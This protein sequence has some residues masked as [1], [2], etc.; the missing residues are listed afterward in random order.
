MKTKLLGII[1]IVIIVIVIIGC[2]HDEPPPPQVN[3]SIGSVTIGGKTIPIY[4]T[5]G[6][7][8]ADATATVTTINTVFNSLSAP[9][10][11]YIATNVTKI[12]IGGN[13]VTI[14]AGVL[15]IEPKIGNGPLSGELNDLYLNSL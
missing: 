5:D 10:A 8:D 9:T 6:V 7:S 15:K 4:K 13:G 12:E 11:N 3:D 14:N 2:K 1:A